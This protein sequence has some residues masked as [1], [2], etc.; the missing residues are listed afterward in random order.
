V[1]RDARSSF[2]TPVPHARTAVMSRSSAVGAARR[3]RAALDAT[4]WC[5]AQRGS[6]TGAASRSWTS[7]IS[8]DEVW[9][10]E[11]WAATVRSRG[12]HATGWAATCTHRSQ[13]GIP[14][15]DAKTTL[16][17]RSRSRS[18]T[19]SASAESG[20]RPRDSPT[21]GLFVAPGASIPAEGVLALNAL[22]DNPGARRDQ[23][24]LGRGRGSGKGKTS[25]RGYNGQKSRS[26]NAL[27]IGF[28]G[29]QTP[30]RLTLP[31]RGFVNVKRM[32]FSP[33]N[34]S[35]VQRW[36]DDGRLDPSKTLTMHHFV[37]SGLI[38][39][40]VGNGVKLLAKLDEVEGVA[41]AA[42]PSAEARRLAAD[43]ETKRRTASRPFASKIDVQVS[44][45]SKRAREIIEGLGGRVTRVHY[46]RLGLRALLKPHKFPDG[47][48]KPARVPV[49]LKNKVDREGT[50]PAPE[51]EAFQ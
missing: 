47:V 25:G 3:L 24:R 35:K 17:D 39:K 42:R 10:P 6:V 44:R 31:K 11:P 46:N 32:T 34:L 12:F 26:G 14:L 8:K 22:R 41:N 48:P 5:A 13:R 45:V 19:S 1:R 21:R 4:V 2:L 33:L 51:E 16:F 37:R 7:P 30:L 23:V 28:E 38:D 40:R 36:I 20:Q 18:F 29:G 49:Y 9:R 27:R 50:L 43:P 15:H